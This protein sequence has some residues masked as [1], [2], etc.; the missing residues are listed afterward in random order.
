MRNRRRRRSGVKI[1]EVIN[2]SFVSRARIVVGRALRGGS[3]SWE[4]RDRDRGDV[5]GYPC[6]QDRGC[7]APA[8]VAVVCESIREVDGR[9]SGGEVLWVWG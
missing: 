8:V 9:E 4:K 7:G 3:R 2:P 6:W 5:R 1:R